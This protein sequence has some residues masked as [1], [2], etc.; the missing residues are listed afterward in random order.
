VSAVLSLDGSGRDLAA[1]WSHYIAA[2]ARVE[3]LLEQLTDV[4]DRLVS[5]LD[6]REGLH[7]EIDRSMRLE[8][9]ALR[10]VARAK[11]RR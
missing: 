1:A 6:E 8:I 2:R 7:D 9:E 4:D 11:D 5:T 3:A 10:Q